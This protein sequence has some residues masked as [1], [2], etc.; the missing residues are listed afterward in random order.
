MIDAEFTAT[1]KQDAE[2]E[3]RGWN[4]I[5]AEQQARADRAEADRDWYQGVAIV[6]TIVVVILSIVA[7]K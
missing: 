4:E 3:W 6:L 1:D 2:R 7:V 5:A